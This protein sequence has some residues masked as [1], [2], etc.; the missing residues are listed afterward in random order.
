M[1]KSY[2]PSYTA[3]Q[4]RIENL[5]YTFGQQRYNGTWVSGSAPVT[6]YAAHETGSIARSGGIN[7]PVHMIYDVPWRDQSSYHRRMVEVKLTPCV[8]DHYRSTYISRTR[9]FWPSTKDKR[10]LLPSAPLTGSFGWSNSDEVDRAVTECLLKMKDA[11]VNVSTLLAESIKSYDMVAQAVTPFWKALLAIKRGN[12]GSLSKSLRG[13]LRNARL[14]GADKR[15]YGKMLEFQ[16]G[17]LPLCSDLYE[18]MEAAQEDIRKGGQI[19]S[20]T[21]SVTN[22]YSQTPARNSDWHNRQQNVEVTGYCHLYAGISNSTLAA[23]AQYGLVNP[24]ELGW[25]VIPFSFLVDWGMPIGNFL[26]AF[27]AG[28]G[29]DF[30]GG[31]KGT[32]VSG[33]ASGNPNHYYEG[34]G[35]SLRAEYHFKSFTRTELNTWPR[36]ILYG[37]SPF[38][39]KHAATALALFRQLN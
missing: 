25:E 34:R 28:V 19:I 32:V 35:T 12:L 37:K 10:P 20:A 22:S 31:C 36:P 11:K 33:T 5:P 7:N 24:L 2:S 4:N 39:T 30:I 1:V 13:S 29:L 26:S 16:Y 9:G 27:D 3:N 17:W 15:I 6:E 38:S 21:R 8:L 23:A 14:A 18:L